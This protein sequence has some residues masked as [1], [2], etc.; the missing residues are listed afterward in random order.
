MRLRCHFPGGFPPRL[1]AVTSREG[2]R[3][4]FAL[5][6][7]GRAFRRG[8]S[9]GA[10]SPGL[11]RHLRCG[12]SP[13]MGRFLW[14]VGALRLRRHFPGGFPPRL[15]A[16]TSRESFPPRMLPRRVTTGLSGAPAVRRSPLTGRF[17]W[18]VGALP[19]RRHFPRKH[20]RRGCSR[21]AS[22]PLSG[23][24]AARHL[25]PYGAVPLGS[26][27]FAFAPL[28]PGRTFRRRRRKQAMPV[29]PGT[30]SRLRRGFHGE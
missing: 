4:A 5:L 18:R 23:A 19:L 24:L 21:G 1:C 29:P 22:I 15:C 6:L 2:S 30:A 3:R 14:K 7:P 12:T 8:C 28:L 20:P 9:R 16:V 10:S 13:L 11:A 25:A 27:C 17:L 26:E